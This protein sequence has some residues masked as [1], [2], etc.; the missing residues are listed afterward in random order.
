M[1]RHWSFALVLLSAASGFAQA[2]RLNVLFLMSDDMRPDLG[3]YGHEVVKSPNIDALAAGRR[4]LRPG[5]LPVS[6]VQSVAHVDAHRPASDDDRRA[7]QPHLVRGGASG[8]R[9]AAQALQGQRLRGA[10]DRQDLPRRHRRRRRLDRRGRSRATSKGPRPIASSRPTACSSRTAAWCWKATAR[11]TATTRPPTGPSSTSASTRTSR[12]SWPAASPSRTAR[13]PRRRGSSTCTTRRSCRCRR[14][15]AAADRARGFSQGL[16]DAQRRPVHRPRRRRRRKPA[17]CC[18][19]TGPR[20]RGPTGTS[21]ACWPSW[22][23]WSCAR[24]RSIVFWGDHGYH[25]GE[26]GKW[27]K[28]GS[29]FEVG[30][31]VP[32]IVVGAGSEG[33]R[34]IVAANRCSRSTSIRRC[35]SCAACRPPA[36]LEG[37]SL[38]RLL[39]DPKGAVGAPGLQRPRHEQQAGGR[40]RADRALSLRRISAARRRRCCSTS[41]PIRTS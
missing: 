7:R 19:P 2:P 10:A 33:E 40:G 17:R 9:L 41:N 8:L 24:R 25:L 35:A 34:P 12:S 20:L 28:H 5:L 36:G 3:C 22:T 18:R 15:F 27:S 39:A 31:R 13:R 6:A 38:S 16:G 21:A 14:T 32:L 37:H 29:L 26:K 4:A 1:L 11:A 30:T 23:A